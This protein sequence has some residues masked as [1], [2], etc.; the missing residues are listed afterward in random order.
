MVQAIA[1]DP[2]HYRQLSTAYIGQRRC[3]V[4]PIATEESRLTV[5]A[6]FGFRRLA[7]KIDSVIQEM[8]ELGPRRVGMC[9]AKI[10]TD[11]AT[12]RTFTNIDAKVC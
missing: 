7:D 2:G 12:V 10:L 1:A 3:E 9:I 6:H 11:H 4:R 8:Y 5:R